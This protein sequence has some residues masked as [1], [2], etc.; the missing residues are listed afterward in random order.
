MLFSYEVKKQRV[1]LISDIH[2]NLSA[3]DLVL[4]EIGKCGV[5]AVICLGDASASGPFP[6]ETLDRLRVEKIPTI[7]GNKDE[8]LLDGLPSVPPET[9]D[10]IRAATD[11]SR[12]RDIDKWCVSQLSETDREYIRSFEKTFTISADNNV[13]SSGLL[14]FH[15]SPR[16]NRD[17]ISSKTPDA[18][19]ATMLSG[20]SSQTMVGGHSHIQL[21]RRFGKITLINPG[22]VGQANERIPNTDQIRRVPWSEYAIITIDQDGFLSGMNF[23]RKQF[24]VSYLHEEAIKSGMPHAEWWADRK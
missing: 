4:E 12:I 22:S 18:E 14:C 19:L 15:G 23:L 1:A 21:L 13:G 11:A 17:L 16:S 20:F 5:D 8:L 6:R 3:L 2:G 9:Q 7:M 10:A 24:D